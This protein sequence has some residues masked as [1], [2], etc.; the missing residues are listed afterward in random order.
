MATRLEKTLVLVG[1]ACSTLYILAL[2]LNMLWLGFASAILGTAAFLWAF[3]L[4]R[5]RR[6]DATPQA[7]SRGQQPIWLRILTL[8]VLVG[9]TL[10]GSWWLPYLGTTLDYS[11]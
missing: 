3:V 10:S 11:Q 7:L 9:V 4:R 5:R 2:P 1:F 8:I 6:R